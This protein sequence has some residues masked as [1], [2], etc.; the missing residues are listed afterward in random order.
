MPTDF[1]ATLARKWA[2]AYTDSGPELLLVG[3]IVAAI[4]EALEE[5]E[6]VASEW[7]ANYPEDIFIPPPP[8]EHGRTVDA[9]SARAERHASKEIIAAIAALREGR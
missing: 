1:V 3:A 8:G 5:A 4:H 9:C 2:D 6:K 7:A